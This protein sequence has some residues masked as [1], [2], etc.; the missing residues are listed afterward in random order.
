MRNSIVLFSTV[1]GALSLGS[2][3]ETKKEDSAI[4]PIQNDSSMGGEERAPQ[5]L[6]DGA[7]TGNPEFENE[8]LAAVYEHYLEV[9]S[10]LVNTNAKEA[11]ETAEM[12][13]E[14]LQAS[15][16]TGNVLE[17]AREIAGTDNIN[18]QRTA[19]SDLSAAMEDLLAGALVSG[20]IYKQFCP[21]A[22]EGA[23]GYWLAS[24][25][26]VRN[27]Y[28]GEMMLKCGRVAETIK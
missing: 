19:F 4:M 13:V 28:Y 7:P 23:G 6:D 21:M 8:H 5:N 20:E 10:A 14:T 1:L 24:S 16:E 3:G 27:P 9:K 11:R 2:C 12:L 26:E 25:E 15:E 17:A 22:F 18:I